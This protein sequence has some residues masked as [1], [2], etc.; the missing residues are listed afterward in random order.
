MDYY[1][2]EIDNTPT[3]HSQLSKLP[4]LKLYYTTC[5]QIPLPDISPLT[6]PSNEQLPDIIGHK[7]E[8][9]S[10]NISKPV[11]PVNVLEA[12]NEKNPYIPS[13]LDNPLTE[14]E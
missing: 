14:W 6:A 1:T 2:N 8:K 12:L 11:K 10:K 5:T 13:E 9:T 4:K 3:D 7:W